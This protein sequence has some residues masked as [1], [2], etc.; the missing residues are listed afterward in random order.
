MLAVETVGTEFATYAGSICPGILQEVSSKAS[1]RRVQRDARGLVLDLQ[2]T[3]ASKRL[4]SPNLGEPT[5]AHVRLSK[6][7]ENM[8]QFSGHFGQLP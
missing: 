4:C 7:C 6:K 5:V 3:K 2:Y 8:V 1:S